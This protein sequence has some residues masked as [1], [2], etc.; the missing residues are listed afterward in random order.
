MS[1]RVRRPPRQM[2]R[3]PEPIQGDMSHETTVIEYKVGDVKKKVTI[4]EKWNS[5]IVE[6]EFGEAL[7]KCRLVRRT[8]PKGI[9]DDISCFTNDLKT[10][11]LLNRAGRFGIVHNGVAHGGLMLPDDS[12]TLDA[13]VQR[14]RVI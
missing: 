11:V 5:L 8:L 2:P 12:V 6:A 9:N 3:E 4:T 1:T 10:R 13:L 14:L 7:L